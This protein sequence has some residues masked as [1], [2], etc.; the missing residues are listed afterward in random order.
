MENQEIVTKFKDGLN[1][2]DEFKVVKVSELV[3]K[4]SSQNCVFT[5]LF[6]RNADAFNI[7]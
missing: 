7:S 5:F 3:W 2:T 1:S 4:I 6:E